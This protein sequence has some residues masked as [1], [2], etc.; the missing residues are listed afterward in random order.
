MGCE[1]ERMGKQKCLLKTICAQIPCQKLLTGETRK[2]GAAL[3]RRNR[4]FQLEIAT[5]LA[6]VREDCVVAAGRLRQQE[7]LRKV[8]AGFVCGNGWQG[9]CRLWC[10]TATTIATGARRI[11]FGKE[12]RTTSCLGRAATRWLVGA[13][14]LSGFGAHRTTS[15]GW[16]ASRLY[17]FLMITSTIGAQVQRLKKQ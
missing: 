15:F 12:T 7:Q 11:V 8:L 13:T 10:R 9:R 6:I 5:P 16:H 14:R 3:L 1:T 2:K 17:V 4:G